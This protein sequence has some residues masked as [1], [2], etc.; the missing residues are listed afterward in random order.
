MLCGKVLDE[1]FVYQPDPLDDDYD[2]EMPKKKP[3]SFCKMC[4]A[5]IK[6]EAGEAQKTP[7][8]M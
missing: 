5:K 3:L 1:E 8:P 4:Q 2:D 6:H 7:K